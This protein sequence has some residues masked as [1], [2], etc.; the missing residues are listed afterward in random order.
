MH[1][2][3][4]VT[5]GKEMSLWS[6]HSSCKSKQAAPLRVYKAISW[7]LHLTQ[8]RKFD[9]TL[10]LTYLS[11]SKIYCTIAISDQAIS[12]PICWEAFYDQRFL[13][14]K[15]NTLVL[16]YK[17]MAVLRWQMFVENL[18][19]NSSLSFSSKHVQPSHNF[20]FQQTTSANHSFSD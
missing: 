16:P 3:H 1:C 9:G 7:S 10:S 13:N 12:D 8:W 14:L 18:A 20:V 5:F 4:S 19:L 6:G 2:K 11:V 15:W 17:N